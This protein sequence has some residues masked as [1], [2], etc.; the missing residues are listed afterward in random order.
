[1]ETETGLNKKYPH[2]LPITIFDYSW[3]KEYITNDEK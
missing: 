2:G 1:M 3:V